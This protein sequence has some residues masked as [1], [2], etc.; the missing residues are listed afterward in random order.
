MCVAQHALLIRFQSSS[1]TLSFF[2]LHLH[3]GLRWSRISRLR[4]YLCRLQPYE[5]RESF[6]SAFNERRK[7]ECGLTSTRLSFFLDWSRTSGYS[8]RLQGLWMHWINPEFYHHRGYASSLPGWC[9]RSYPLPPWSN[10]YGL[11]DANLQPTLA[12]H[13]H[14]HWRRSCVYDG[15]GGFGRDSTFREGCRRRES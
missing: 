14:L 15:R 4:Y 10:L 13:F 1:L 8:L 3:Q 9:R 2:F 12:G 6:S 7:E 5:L 11:A